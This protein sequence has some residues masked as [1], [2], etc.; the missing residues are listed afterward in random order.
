MTL[1]K[2]NTKAELDKILTKLAKNKIPYKMLRT[3]NIIVE[4]DTKDRDLIAY[5]KKNNPELK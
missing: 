4:L 5:A 2:D 3:N 1:L